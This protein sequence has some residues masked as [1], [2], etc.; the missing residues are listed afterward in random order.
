[1]KTLTLVTLSIIAV[2]LLAMAVHLEITASRLETMLSNDVQ[3]TREV[4]Q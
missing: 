2:A 3:Y 1:M 4:G